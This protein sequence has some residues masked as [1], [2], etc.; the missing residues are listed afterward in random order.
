MLRADNGAAEQRPTA[1]DYQ[2]AVDAASGA[3][4]EV[5]HPLALPKGWTATSVAFDPTGKTAW[6]IGVLT[7]GEK[8]V[9]VRQEDDDLDDLLATY[10]DENPVRGDDVTLDSPLA[11]TWSTWSDSGGDHAYAATIDVQGRQDVVLVYGSAPTADLRS[12]LES[13]VL[14]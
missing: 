2:E 3:G 6:G 5:V 1:V 9:G 7:S 11:S 10:V 4:I 12:F 8:F 14:D 13:L